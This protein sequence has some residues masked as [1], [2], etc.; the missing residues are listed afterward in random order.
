MLAL[1]SPVL[2]SLTW[3]VFG[4]DVTEK[5]TS[6]AGTGLP[7]DVMVAV[8]VWLVPA[9]FC[10][11]AGVRAMFPTAAVS[12]PFRQRPNSEPPEAIGPTST[13]PLAMLKR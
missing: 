11:V 12:S 1:H 6:S 2:G 10:A 13:A 5:L 7:P 3:P 9:T 4:P 8:T